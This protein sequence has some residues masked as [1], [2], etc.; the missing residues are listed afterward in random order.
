MV[1]EILSYKTSII[2]PLLKVFAIILF[3]I[4]AYLLFRCLRQYG[5]VLRQVATLLCLGAFAGLLASAFR[6]EGDF[7]QQYKWGESVLN[8]IIVLIMLVI[9]LVIRARMNAAV[10]VFETGQGGDQL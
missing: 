1:I 5:G 6:F 3:G 10:K 2:N 4:A 7:Y 8:L 9:A